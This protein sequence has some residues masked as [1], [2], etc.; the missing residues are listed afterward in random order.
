[1]TLKRTEAKVLQSLYFFNRWV[2]ISLSLFGASTCTYLF[3][4]IDVCNV[5]CF[6]QTSFLSRFYATWHK[7]HRHKVLEFVT[8]FM[9]SPIYQRPS[10]DKSCF[11]DFWVKF[12]EYHREQKIHNRC[13]QMY[14]D[15]IVANTLR[16]SKKNW[17]K[18]QLIHIYK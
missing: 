3:N 16:F 13:K 1:V 6:Y 15:I 17:I 8:S 9:N 10:Y 7:F 2:L 4:N 5:T 12:A 11:S 18:F 14:I